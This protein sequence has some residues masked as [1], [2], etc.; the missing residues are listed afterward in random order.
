MAQNLMLLA[1]LEEDDD[2]LLLASVDDEKDSSVYQKL[3]I[4]ELSND[5][6]RNL[7]RFQREDMNSLCEA[8]DFPSKIVCPN[9]TVCSGTEGLSILIRRL[10]YP[11]RLQDLSHIFGRSTAELS[12]I[13]NTVLNFIDT[14]HGHRIERL[15][16]PWL[17]HAKLDEMATAI[18]NC[19]APLSNCWG[20]IDGTVRPICRPQSYQQLVFNGHKRVHGLKFQCIT[21]PDGMIAHLFG[22]IE[23]RRH[24]AGML[25]ESDVEHQLQQ[26][27]TK[28]NNDVYSLYGDPAYP[29]SPYLI[30]P[31]RGGVISA[32]QMRF[33]KR[34]SA[35]R[36]CVEWT[37]SKILNL[38]A[39][40]DYKKNQKLY[41]QPVG[42]YYRVASILTN[43]HTILYGSETGTFFGIDPPSLQEYLA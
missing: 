43:C 10:A 17:S 39:F 5:Q 2:L 24:D 23:G 31:F 7:F 29:L 34:M 3:E 25:R 20:F 15:N 36:V 16:H 30:P 28:A 27:M 37:F 11:N 1:C 14:R 42:K 35:V 13:F 18:S 40:L 19:G 22:P 6:F 21:T 26:Y 4:D 12:Y 33:N 32:N 9:R 41:L 8:L 38:F